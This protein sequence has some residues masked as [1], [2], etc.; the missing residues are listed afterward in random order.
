MD[1]NTAAALVS[2]LLASPGTEIG[3]WIQ[4]LE[5]LRF[6][7]ERTSDPAAGEPDVLGLIEDRDRLKAK[8]L[9]QDRLL[10]DAEQAFDSVRIPGYRLPLPEWPLS[11]RIEGL[12][13]SVRTYK[14]NA[15]FYAENSEKQITELQKKLREAEKKIA[16]FN[17]TDED[18]GALPLYHHLKASVLD[19][20]GWKTGD[21]VPGVSKP[22]DKYTL[23]ELKRGLFVAKS[24]RESPKEAEW[25][26]WADRGD[27]LAEALNECS[28]KFFNVHC[29]GR[30]ATGWTETGALEEFK[31]WLK[32]RE[33]S[34][35]PLK[36][37]YET[38]KQAVMLHLALGGPA[39][40]WTTEQLVDELKKSPSL[41]AIDRFVKVLNLTA[42]NLF[43][44]PYESWKASDWFKDEHR[45]LIKLESKIM[46]L[47]VGI[48]K[49]IKE[50]EDH[51]DRL[52][53]EKD[54]LVIH[55]QADQK[56]IEALEK[57][58][59]DLR[60]NP[61]NYLAGQVLELLAQVQK[62]NGEVAR[63]L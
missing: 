11:R 1:K 3:D 59:K 33:A 57:E 20:L 43:N 18:K 22:F 21:D 17:D 13:E 44:L 12:L 37:M 10:R 29:G 30:T 27:A 52:Q 26:K 31:K 6:Y 36:R 39:D 2:Q 50:L 40:K 24:N 4:D 14:G 46:E 62:L 61:S 41:W 51:R 8:V 28:A 38:L 54:G 60:T 7:I 15:E 9:S 45:E 55:A 49:R 42:R 53:K 19:F 23:Q 34:D 25:R 5:R 63:R 48:P 58:V 47:S 35:N 32:A 56:K 16:E